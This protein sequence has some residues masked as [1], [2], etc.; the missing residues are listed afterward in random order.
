MYVQATIAVPNDVNAQ[1]FFNALQCAINSVVSAT[2]TQH[3]INVSAYVYN[4]NN[5]PVY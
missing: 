1:Q 4:S 2:Q 5:E 3:A